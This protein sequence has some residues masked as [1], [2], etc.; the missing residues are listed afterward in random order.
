MSFCPSR[1]EGV[2]LQNS[3]INLKS[4]TWS[5]YKLR[6][7][8]VQYVH[9][10]RSMWSLCQLGFCVIVLAMRQAQQFTNSNSDASCI[11]QIQ[12]ARLVADNSATFCGKLHIGHYACFWTSICCI[13]TCFQRSWSRRVDDSALS[14]G[15]VLRHYHSGI[16]GRS[17]CKIKVLPSLPS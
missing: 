1:F 3:K 15:P 9:S 14:Q 13:A 17:T 8:Q 6:L 12:K 5:R 10:C 11:K 4:Q 2:H 16:I 7:N